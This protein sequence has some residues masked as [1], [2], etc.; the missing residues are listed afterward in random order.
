MKTPAALLGRI[1]IAAFVS[2]ILTVA[3]A[4]AQHGG[5]GG[6]GGGGHSG[7]GHGGAGSHG[8]GSHGAGGSHGGATAGSGH[9]GAASIGPGSIGAMHMGNPTMSNGSSSHASS[10]RPNWG[11]NVFV[12]PNASTAERVAPLPAGTMHHGTAPYIWQEPPAT[13][14]SHVALSPTQ[15]ASLRPGTTMMVHSRVP[16]SSPHML[17]GV[18]MTSVPMGARV[19]SQM[20]AESVPQPRAFFFPHHRFFHNDAFFFLFG[21]GHRRF[22]FFGGFQFQQC[23]FNG[24]GSVCAFEPA[25]FSPFFFG[26]FGF[27]DVGW[28]WNGYGRNY[29]VAAQPAEQQPEE[30]SPP[31]E[32]STYQPGTAPAPAPL[33]LGQANASPLILLVLKDGSVYGV[34]D[35]WLEE[36][37][38]HYLTSYGGENNISIDQLDLQKTV[39]ENWERGVEFVLLTAN[40]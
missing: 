40:K 25:F 2:A 20:Y 26:P 16:L 18:S 39:D 3:P 29:N 27:G 28:G 14:P 4:Y 1:L 34:T 19:G 23:F 30:T 7:G 33:P 15:W 9:S 8:G 32:Y 22:R 31:N 38:L 5:G 37:R 21:F 11:P 17:R 24:F 10:S 35:Y 12:P 13:Y 6:H 36:G